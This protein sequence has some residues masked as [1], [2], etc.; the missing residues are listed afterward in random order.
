LYSLRM[1]QPLDPMWAAY[2][3]SRSLEARN[4]LVVMYLPLV[5][6][7]AARMGVRKDNNFVSV[8][9]CEGYGH[10]GLIRGVEMYNP[11]KGK[12]K[13]YIQM[14]IKGTIL[15][16]LR[17]VDHLKK[18]DR[19]LLKEVNKAAEEFDRAGYRFDDHDLAEQTG[20]PVERIWEI[21]RGESQG[22]ATALSAF[23]KPGEDE[24][25]YEPAYEDDPSERSE[26]VKES[27]RRAWAHLGDKNHIAAL[28]LFHLESASLRD[29]YAFLRRRRNPDTRKGV[30]QWVSRLLDV[31]GP[32]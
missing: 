9:E 8:D 15:D 5:R 27:M 14:R 22:N 21:R 12:P 23:E 18:G 26:R 25:K 10:L 6:P 4:A 16:N 2:L 30:P 20:I 11:E 28:V 29:V 31:S 19:A 24:E 1:Q 17:V 3:G 13:G 32:S 7:I